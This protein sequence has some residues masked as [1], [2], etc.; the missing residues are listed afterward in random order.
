MRK[1]L[2][3]FIVV[4]L[5]TG[6]AKPGDPITPID[7]PTN[8]I[9]IYSTEVPTNGYAKDVH[10]FENYIVVAEDEGGVSIINRATLQ[11]YW[12]TQ[13][14]QNGASVQLVKNNCIAYDP[15]NNFVAFTESDEA[16]QGIVLDISDIDNPRYV[17]GL[18]GNMSGIKE[19]KIKYI[20]EMDTVF[21][22]LA[23]LEYTI[24]SDTYLRKGRLGHPNVPGGEENITNLGFLPEGGQLN[25]QNGVDGFDEDD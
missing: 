24:A 18:T 14:S 21:N 25:L 10:A 13:Y 9:L 19:M 15:E 2:F 3:L 4:I 20:N 5:F 16:D 1:V 22:M 8:E 23:I 6:C 12:I 7:G 11:R 17:I